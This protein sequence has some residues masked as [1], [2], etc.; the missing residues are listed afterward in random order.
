VSIRPSG[1]DYEF[2]AIEGESNE[3]FSAYKEMF[4]V[5][6]T[7]D[8]VARNIL[9]VY[10]PFVDFII[11][12]PPVSLPLP[13]LPLLSSPI[14]FI[15]QSL[16][17]TPSFVGLL[18]TSFKRKKP[19]F[20]KVNLKASHMLVGICLPSYVKSSPISC[21]FC[22]ILRQLNRIWRPMFRKTSVSRTRISSIISIRS[23]L[24]DQIPRPSP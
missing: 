13:I 11:V 3:L 7:G 18:V 6:I 21:N 19:R 22:S 8:S 24:Q 17:A 9:R 12:N 1:F 5:T 23:C 2:N 20:F 15:A 14:K 10:L 4:E 16:D